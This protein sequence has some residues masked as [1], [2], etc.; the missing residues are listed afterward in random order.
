[1]KRLYIFLIGLLFVATSCE[2]DFDE[3]NDNPYAIKVME[4]PNEVRTFLGN[5]VDNYWSNE[6]G[7]WVEYP[8]YFA[9]RYGTVK[10]F[11]YSTSHDKLWEWGFGQ[12][13]SLRDAQKWVTKGAKYEHE[14]MEAML[15]VAEVIIFAKLADTYGDIPFTQAGY[16][17]D[18]LHPEYEKH[19]DIYDKMLVLLDEADALFAVEMTKDKDNYDPIYKQD[20]ERWMRLG[21]SLRFRFAMHMRMS[22]PAKGAALMKK[23]ME[24]D[25]INSTAYHLSRNQD[26][27]FSWAWQ[28]MTISKKLADFY[29]AHND[30]RINRWAKKNSDGEYVGFPS[31]YVTADE[32]N[33]SAG[34]KEMGKHF[35]SKVFDYSEYCFLMAEAHLFGYGYEK[36]IEK[37]NE[38]Y[39]KGIISDFRGIG[40]KSIP[41]PE[42]APDWSIDKVDDPENYGIEEYMAQDYASLDL[43][44][45]DVTANFEKIMT[46]KWVALMGNG[47]EAFVEMRRTG[48]PTIADRAGNDNYY[49]D[50]TNG[51]L[52]KRLAYPLTERIYNK[53]NYD[54]AAEVY[55]GNRL[56]VK[57]FWD[58][59]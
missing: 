28:S 38:F 35:K 53:K 21:N 27:G 30:P 5:I 51:K 24:R 36:N 29:V 32:I 59:D 3:I 20:P 42:D 10:D 41:D 25:L 31:G 34:F 57:L 7:I 22:H 55:N 15:K 1:M 4:V 19:I 37:A 2:K 39:R 11:S 43:T 17:N 40:F 13:R 50:D 18:Y 52:P 26:P 48:I 49:P 23:V 14:H 45:T 44:T 58:V 56:D 46:Q 47:V 54:K 6:I 12:L 16:G 8:Q 33:Y 9:H